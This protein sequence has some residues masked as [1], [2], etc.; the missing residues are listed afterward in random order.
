MLRNRSLSIGLFGPSAAGKST[1]IKQFVE[2][3]SPD[4]YHPIITEVT[5]SDICFQKHIFH[6][7]IYNTTGSCELKQLRKNNIEKS[8][9]IV[10]VFDLSKIES[11]HKLKSFYQECVESKGTE[12]FPL[13]IVGNKIDLKSSISFNDAKEY[14]TM[15]NS[16]YLEISARNK[17][18]V[19]SILK[20][21]CSLMVRKE[22]PN[23]AEK[24]NICCSFTH[25]SIISISSRHHDLPRV[26]S[27]CFRL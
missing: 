3:S 17:Y 25:K 11:F 13:V 22:N 12:N 16:H 1:I 18:E 7:T 15:K 2:G 8:D 27:P 23:K 21:A 26:T 6:L 10:L 5:S 24:E 19:Q 14:F 20:K 4:E 9:V